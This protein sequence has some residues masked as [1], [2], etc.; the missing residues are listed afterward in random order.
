MLAQRTA[1]A[2]LI[3]TTVS[4]AR[5][6]QTIKWMFLCELSSNLSHAI[7]LREGRAKGPR[8]IVTPK[9]SKLLRPI[10]GS[11][12]QWYITT[13]EEVHITSSFESSPLFWIQSV[14]VSFNSTFNGKGTS[15]FFSIQSV[16]SHHL[17]SVCRECMYSVRAQPTLSRAPHWPKSALMFLNPSWTGILFLPTTSHG[18][19]KSYQIAKIVPKF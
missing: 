19:T 12:C 10:L 13:I 15:L 4:A 8:S 9:L 7:H 16:N 5:D 11:Y 14:T 17:I 6:R 3:R 2:W 1:Y 18:P